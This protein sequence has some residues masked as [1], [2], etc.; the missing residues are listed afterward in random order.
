MQKRRAYYSTSTLGILLALAAACRGQ[1]EI[2]NSDTLGT[3]YTLVDTGQMQCFS[4]HGELPCEQADLQ[5]PRQDA[6]QQ[7]NAARYRDNGDGTVDDLV[8]GLT[9]MKARGEKMTWDEAMQGAAQLSLGG[10]RDWRVPTI[11]ELY[12][13]IDFNGRSAIDGDPAHSIPYLDTRVFDF[14]YGQSSAGERL[15]DAQD[16][17][18]TEYVGLTMMGDATVFGVNFA[19]GR[20]KGYPKVFPGR[21]ANRL[22]VRYVRGNPAYGRNDFV[23]ATQSIHDRATGL[24]WQR[25]D[26]GTPLDWAAALHY[27]ANLR[28]EGESDWRLPNAKELQS[29]IDYSRAPAVTSSPAIDPRFTTSQ[30]ESYFWTST[31]HLEGPGGGPGSAAVYVAFG[32]ALGRIEMPPMSGQYSPFLDVHGAGAQRSDPKQ[33]DPSVYG[34][35]STPQGDD[36]RIRN[37]VRCVR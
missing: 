23:E 9:W 26:S 27:C 30:I 32:R 1:K 8:T 21:G 20:I 22:F 7:G 34:P 37:Y 16:W 29:L 5:F 31:T 25:D 36:V 3:R 28:H 11:K 24:V 4:E 33:G 15:I 17:S 18:A 19:D 6:H 14:A 12:S 35:Q 10:A 13:L 2:S